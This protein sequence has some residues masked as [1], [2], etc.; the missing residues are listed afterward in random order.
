MSKFYKLLLSVSLA[1]FAVGTTHAESKEVTIG[2]LPVLNP[3]IIPMVD[4][5]FE[6][7]TGYKINWKQFDSGAS[8]ILGM[9][10]GAV[11]IGYAGSSPSAAARPTVSTCPPTRS[12][13]KPPLGS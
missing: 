6:K 5:T 4:K 8:V 13:A 11:Q 3:W 9:S 10:S 2:Y 1:L 12:A 7:E